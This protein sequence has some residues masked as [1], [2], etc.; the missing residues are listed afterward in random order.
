MRTLNPTQRLGLVGRVAALATLVIVALL[1]GGSVQADTARE[2][3]NH[4][5]VA[6]SASPQAATPSSLA[7]I[8]GDVSA[9]GFTNQTVRNIVFTS[10][11]GSALR[12]RLTNSFGSQPVT[13][14][15]VDV[16][17]VQSGATLASGSSQI[18]TF[19]GK[20]T[21][22]IAPGAQALSD[23]VPLAVQPLAHLAVSLFSAGATGPASYHF[24]ANQTNYIAAGNAASSAS[25]AAFTTTTAAWYFVDD[26]DVLVRPEVRNAIIALGDSI[27]DGFGSTP[28]ANHR[29]PNLL[30]QRFLA[31][32]P[33]LVD[34]VVDQG[35]SGN[36]VL[37]NSA[38]FGVDTQARLDRDVLTQTGVQFVIL[39]EGINDIG[40]SQLPNS[41]CSSPNTDVSADEIIAGYQQII[42]QV[43]AE[44]LKIFGGTLTPFQGAFYFSVAGEAKR[45]AVNTF[46]RT[47]GA[48]DGVID[49]E[50]AV[51]DPSNPLQFLPLDDSG[52]HLHP[53]DA[54]YQA[55]ANAVNLALFRP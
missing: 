41:G 27:T 17:L 36:R 11:G 24:N 6:W 49:F 29:W 54:G 44:G 40:F 14:N 2:G 43:H 1:P 30:A 42:A 39:L 8:P 45:E 25:G 15:E 4:W 53:N 38:C 13:F 10:V 33:G 3:G 9:V 12:V 7:F 22:T 47:S 18:A 35:I 55:M 51:R 32:P 5:L 16:G 48:F 23:P 52:D 37:N 21:V 19:A 31:G 50:K 26:V 46:V 28:N 20:A 34:S